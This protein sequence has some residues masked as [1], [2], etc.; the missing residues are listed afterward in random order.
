MRFAISGLIWVAGF[1]PGSE[2]QAFPDL[3]RGS[4]L[5]AESRLGVS[6]GC[7]AERVDLSTQRG[8]EGL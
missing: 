7:V 3:L 1:E 2:L 5:L 8:S 6:W 4:Q